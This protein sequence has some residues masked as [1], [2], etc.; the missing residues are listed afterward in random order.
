MIRI[1]NDPP[2]LINQFVA[3]MRD[4]S[5][6]QDRWRFRKNMERLGAIFAYEISK[7]FTYTEKGVE[8][9]LGIATMPLP[10]DRVVIASILRAG[11]PLQQGMLGFFDKA[12]SA[13]V[14]AYRKHHKDGS[15]DIHQQYTSCPDLTGSQLIL[16]DPMIATG[17]SMS[18]SLNGLLEF[19]QPKEIHFVTIIAANYGVEYLQ[20]THPEANIWVAALDE[21]LTAK[22]YIVP[23]LGDAG[24]LSFGNKL[25]E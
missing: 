15:F 4:V 8:S 9:P 18:V 3:E 19:G 11:L 25:Q 21:E 20:R 22:M 1:I 7:T 2:S 24:D 23:G 13:F 16:C 14:S 10:S 5:T 12:D 6:Q 17:S